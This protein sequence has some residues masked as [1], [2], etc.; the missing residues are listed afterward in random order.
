MLK[1]YNELFNSKIV[2]MDFLGRVDN[3]WIEMCNLQDSTLA[4]NKIIMHFYCLLFRGVF[5]SIFFGEQHT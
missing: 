2:L 1:K 5:S 4:K 3:E